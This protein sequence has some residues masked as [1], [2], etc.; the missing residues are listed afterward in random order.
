MVCVR[1]SRHFVTG[2]LYL[3]AVAHVTVHM[4]GVF[5]CTRLQAFTV[6]SI[7]V[8]VYVHIHVYMCMLV[9]MSVH[10]YSAYM[11]EEIIS[12]SKHVCVHEYM[13]VHIQ[14]LPKAFVSAHMKEE[15]MSPATQLCCPFLVCM[16]ILSSVSESKWCVNV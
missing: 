16:L 1:F 13:Y 4:Q 9:C 3:H 11:R 8:C 14:A 7:C 12:L 15:R 5:E 6:T 2:C 10:T